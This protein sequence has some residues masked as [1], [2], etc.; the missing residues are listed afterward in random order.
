MLA[1]KLEDTL[2]DG[3]VLI[4]DCTLGLAG[5]ILGRQVDRGKRFEN[6][7][8]CTRGRWWRRCWHG[9][10][11]ASVTVKAGEKRVQVEIL[12]CPLF[13]VVVVEVVVQVVC[14]H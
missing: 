6:C 14:G 12:K 2:V 9:G 3:E 11:S 1:A 10:R 4:A 5:H 13:E 8:R 7:L